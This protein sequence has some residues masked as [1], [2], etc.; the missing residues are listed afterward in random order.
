MIG[1]GN[2]KKVYSPDVY[3]KSL[4]TASPKTTTFLDGAR[5]VLVFRSCG[6]SP[7]VVASGAKCPLS[8]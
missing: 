5:S 7:P 6:A 3:S 2:F 1:M 4:K 8:Y